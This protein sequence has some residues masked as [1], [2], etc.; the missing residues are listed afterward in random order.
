[1]ATPYT[2][3]A[4]KYARDVVSGKIDACKWVKAACQR[5]LDDL[6]RWG[7]KSDPYYFD[8]KKA[9]HVC[10]FIEK[11]PHVRGKWA[12]SN[13]T[14]EPWQCFFL[15][16]VFGWMRTKDEKRR[17]R[18]VYLEVP[19]KNGKSIIAADIGLYLFTE[20]EPGAEIFAGATTEKQ[21]WEVFRPAHLMAK[22]AKGFAEHY[23]IDVN[24]SNIHCL[25]TAS[26]FE[27]LIG[28]PGDGASPHCA[29]VDEYH[30]HPDPRLYDTMVTGMGAREQPL[31][32]VTTTAG[33]DTSSPCYDKRSQVCKILDK[34]DGF[35]NDEVFGIIYTIND[36]AD[37]SDFK[38]WKMANPNFGVSVFEDYLKSR[39]KEAIQRA[40][41]QNIIRCKHLNQWMSAGQ[42]FFDPLKWA[43]CA[44]TSLGLDDFKGKKCWIGIDLASKIDLAAMVLLFFFEGTYYVF[45]KFYLPEDALEGEDKTHYQGWAHDGYITTTMG[46]MVDIDM[47]EEDLR[48]LNRKFNVLEVPH[49]PWNAAQFV[50]HMTKERIPMVEIAQTVNRMSDPLKE[51]EALILE[52]RI[53]HDGNPVMSWCM[54]NT[55]ARYDKK[56]NV[57]PYKERPENKIDGAIALVMALASA[58]RSKDRTSV[59]ESRGM[60]VL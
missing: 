43:A 49:D 38:V 2:T 25:A 11:L 6:K 14:L 27:P 56:D 42:A 33:V 57:F 41:R 24:A 17:F 15:T 30:E 58:T 7:K 12:G 1:M 26:R 53:R 44:D 28:N 16:T 51:L 20:G 48:D 59:Y 45:P 18:E 32:V 19:R 50:Q 36:D 54:S 5:Q 9:D 29:L 52:D 10:R 21:A 23:G 39:H 55:V 60:A 8:K 35:E 4:T 3:K 47:I 37:W 34:V 46:S 31:I 22:R 13:Q 40:S